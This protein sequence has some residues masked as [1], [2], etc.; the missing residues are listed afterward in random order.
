LD[1]VIQY[2]ETIMKLLEET[3]TDNWKDK[4]RKDVVK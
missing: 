2:N 4:I 3:F 1:C